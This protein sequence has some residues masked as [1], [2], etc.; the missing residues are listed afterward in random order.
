MGFTYI[1]QDLEEQLEQ[2][3]FWNQLSRLT[4]LQALIIGWG[5]QSSSQFN[6]VAFSLDNGLKL[7]APLKRLVHFESGS[8]LNWH[9]KEVEWAIQTWPSLC[10][11][12]GKVQQDEEICDELWKRLH[13]AGISLRGYGGHVWD[14]IDSEF[15]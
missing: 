1:F 6:S 2:P 8:S 5:S 4:Q 14:F 9:E 13:S 7:L 12:Q 10:S 11:I 3:A 15:E